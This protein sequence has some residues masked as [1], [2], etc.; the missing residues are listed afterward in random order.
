MMVF[1]AI[2]GATT[3][4]LDLGL[5]PARRMSSSA[6][7]PLGKGRR[8]RGGREGGTATAAMPETVALVLGNFQGVVVLDMGL[9][10]VSFW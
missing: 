7:G 2:A 3:D 8:R 4:D 6:D 9:V 5:P 1:G 10:T